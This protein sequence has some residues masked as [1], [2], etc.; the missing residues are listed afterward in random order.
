MRVNLP[1]YQR[2][3]ILL[4]I[5]LVLLKCPMAFAESAIDETK[6]NKY[7]TA[8]WNS[9]NNDL[10]NGALEKYLSHWDENAERITPTVHAK[11]IKEI[12]ATYKSYLAAYSDFHQEEIRRVIDGNVVVSELVTTARNKASGEMMSLPNVAIVELN[13]KGKVIRARV[14]L[15]TRKFNPKAPASNN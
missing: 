7:V 11:G 10:S 15:D 6:T 12:R 3:Y 8:F 4:I 2:H 5:S 9:F 14:Y 1:K 13:E